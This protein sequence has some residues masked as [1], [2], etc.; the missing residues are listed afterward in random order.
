ML[1][2]PLSMR[3]AGR[4]VLTF[5]RLCSPV[6]SAASKYPIR[7]TDRCHALTSQRWG[8]PMR[9]VSKPEL[10]EAMKDCLRDL[11]NTKLISPDDLDIID[12]KR[13]LRR[14]IDELQNESSDGQQKV[15]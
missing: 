14:Q 6:R 4:C 10:V 9:D 2:G 3:V 1:Y 5:L 7:S 11:E 8:V 13:I 15:V 12:E